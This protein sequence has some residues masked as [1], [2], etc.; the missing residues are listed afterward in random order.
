MAL[1]I[2]EVIAG[3][4]A[5]IEVLEPDSVRAELALLGS[6]LVERYTPK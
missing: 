5:S 6:E 2:A 4:G 3:W 1:S